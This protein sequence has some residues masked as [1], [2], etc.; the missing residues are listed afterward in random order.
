MRWQK[1]SNA[2]TGK[3]WLAL[4]GTNAF[5]GLAIVVIAEELGKR[6]T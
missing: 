2:H 1:V 6:S 3:D 5:D 4:D